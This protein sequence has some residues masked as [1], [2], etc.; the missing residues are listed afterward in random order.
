MHQQAVSDH[1]KKMWSLPGDLKEAVNACLGAHFPEYVD[2][3]EDTK[4]AHNGQYG[5]VFRG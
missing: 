5:Q 3:T 2:K 4:T 1:A